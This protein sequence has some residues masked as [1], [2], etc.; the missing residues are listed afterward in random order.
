MP[1]A[2]P[3]SAAWWSDR[4][5]AIA[6][7]REALATRERAGLRKRYQCDLL[8]FWRHCRDAPCRRK[9]ACIG[10][11]DGCLAQ[12]LAAMS[13]QDKEWL[14]GAIMATV[15]GARSGAITMAELV[16]RTGQEIAAARCA[17]PMDTQ[18][19]A[20]WLKPLSL[21]EPAGPS[22]SRQIDEQAD[23]EARVVVSEH[24]SPAS[25]G[26]AAAEPA[27]PAAGAPPPAACRST[28]PL[29][30]SYACCDEAGRLIMPDLTEHK[31]R[32]R[33]GLTW[34]EIVA[35]GRV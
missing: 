9:H 8:Q 11:P 13:G 28:G 1:G 16:R 23:G 31:E 35:R 10:D 12:G 21:V 32:V 14:R 29:D 25:P 20:T 22:P 26:T 7:M 15:K 34:G 6:R 5:R 2:K 4:R 17:K 24:K 18:Q 3:K 33:R 30:Q 19:L 27:L